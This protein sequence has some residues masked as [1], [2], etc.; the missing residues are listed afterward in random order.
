MKGLGFVRLPDRKPMSV[1]EANGVRSYLIP[2]PSEIFFPKGYK[3]RIP[4]KVSPD[5]TF[6]FTQVF[7]KPGR[8][9]VSVWG[10]SS[11]AGELEIVGLHFFKV[12]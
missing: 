12:E 3:T 5:G 10:P 7:D 6:E 4:L 8:W 9:E 2:P 1:R 11:T